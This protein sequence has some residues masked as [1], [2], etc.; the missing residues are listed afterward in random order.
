M[1]TV[2][3]VSTRV[4]AVCIRPELSVK[5]DVFIF[6]VTIVE[7]TSVEAVSMAFGTYRVLRVE[8]EKLPVMSRFSTEMLFTAKVVA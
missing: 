1:L 3:A 6:A 5:E 7:A 4:E 2:E 8:P